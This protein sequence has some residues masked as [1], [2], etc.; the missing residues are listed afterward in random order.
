LNIVHFCD[1]HFEQCS[2]SAKALKMQTVLGLGKTDYV[3]AT[4][5][6]REI[7]APAEREVA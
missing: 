4:A 3:V 7:A 6:A 5:L 1:I 2:F